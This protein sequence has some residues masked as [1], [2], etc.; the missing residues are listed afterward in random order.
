MRL[1]AGSVFVLGMTSPAFAQNPNFIDTTRA[2]PN[3][4]SGSDTLN[5]VMDDLLLQLPLSGGIN[6]YFGCGSSCGERQLAGSPSSGDGA[7]NGCTPSDGNG[8]PEANPGC[9]E[10]SGM[11]RPLQSGICDDDPNFPGSTNDQ[12]EGLAFCADGLVIL[13]NNDSIGA[14]GTDAASCAA[15]FASSTTPNTGNQFPDRGVGALRNSGTLASGYQIADWKDVIR[16]VYT[17]CTNADGTCA[18]TTNRVTRCGSAVRREVVENW[19]NLFQGVACSQSGGCPSGLVRA[20][21]RDDA[22]GTTGVFLELIGVAFNVSTNITSRADVVSG[23]PRAITPMPANLSF[24]DGGDIEGVIP[25]NFGPSG[26]AAFD[27]GDPIRTACLAEDDICARDGRLGLVRA[28][29][30]TDTATVAQAYPDYQCKRLFAYQQYINAALN[31][32]PDGTK[33]SAGRCRFPYYEDGAFRTFNCIANQR[34]ASPAAPAGTDGRSYNFVVHADDGTVSFA[35]LNRRLPVTAYWRHN[36]A[37]LNNS[38]LANGKVLTAADVVCQESDATRNIGCLTANSKCTLGYAGREAAFNNSQP[39]VHLSNEPVKLNG[40]PPSGEA[41]SAGS[42][43]FSR[44]LFMNASRGFENIME[45]CKNRGGTKAY[46]EDQ[47]RIA[48]EFFTVGQPGNVLGDICSNAG[49]IPLPAAL[50]VGAQGSAGCGAP[51]SQP[52]SACAIDARS[53]DSLVNN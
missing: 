35:D 9:Q 38:A 29:R 48:Q 37:V 34:S 43:P 31:I 12:A 40:F 7:N 45:D 11:S 22:S 4:I 51:S 36:M 46:C 13:G 14:Y 30:S 33:T 28:I 47:V 49:F 50:C 42:Y 39:T 8:A 21:R 53:Y 5:K 1:V 44:L 26:E 10:I 2:T 16:L 15:Y 6:T 52:L 27:L 23:I 17:G 20:F 18:N 3:A 24:C 25:T 19:G 32:C 41:V